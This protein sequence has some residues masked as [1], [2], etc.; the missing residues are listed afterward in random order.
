MSLTIGPPGDSDAAAPSD[1]SASVLDFRPPGLPPDVPIEAARHWRMLSRWMNLKNIA[2]DPETELPHDHSWIANRVK[3]DYEIDEQSRKEWKDKYRKWLE[4]ALQITQPKT[5]PWPDA[6]NVIYPLM[7]TAATQ[8]NARAYPA[9]IRDR[10]VV[11]GT[12]V[13]SDNGIPIPDPRTGGPLVNP[14]NGQPMWAVPPGA[15]QVRADLIGRHMSW[16]LLDEQEEWEP[17]TDRLLVVL[18]IVGCMF[19]KSYFGH[20]LRRNVS[21]TVDAIDLCVNYWAKSFETAPRKTQIIRKYPWEIQTA[22]RSG[23]FLSYDE[24]SLNL[25]YGRDVRT[26]EDHRPDDQQ[27]EDAPVTFLEQH[28]RMDLDDDGYQEPYVVT[29]ARDSVKLARIRPDFEMEGIRWAPDGRITNVEEVEYF[30]KYGFIPNP[31]STVYDLGFGHLLYPL[32]ESINTSLNMMF[33]AGHLQN[34][35]GGF[36]GSGLSIN[37]GAVRFALGEYKP[38]NTMGGSIRD[39]VFPLPFPGPSPVLMQLLTFL[40]E[41]A[42]RVAAVKDVMTGEMPPDNTSGLAL[43][44]TIEQGLNVFNAIYKRI[45]R[46]LGYEFRKLYRLNRIYLPE[47]G[48]FGRHGAWEEIRRADYEAGSGVE[49]VS[50]PKMVTDMQRLGRAQLLLNFKDDPGFD[51]AA[52]RKEILTAAMIPNPDRFLAQNPQPPAPILLKSR[53]LDIREK[54]EATDLALRAAHD[55][56]LMMREITQAEL[57]LA[58]ARKLDNDAGLSWAQHEL[59]RLKAQIDALGAITDAVSAQAAPAGGQPQPGNGAPAGP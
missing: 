13:G 51:G 20:T 41:A 58:Q 46:S 14:Q 29:I 53:E 16:Q 33:D 19:R 3:Q 52:I 59:D 44:A 39:N 12:V 43:L 23:E 18:P 30:T 10:N 21:E 31:E 42:E 36:V 35:G 38:V 54:R 24:D 25:G 15:K 55:R 8:F 57:N 17:Q 56:A 32:N 11:K 2:D 34:T 40:V 5:Y 26:T 22:V 4:F 45:Y 49:P 37:T 48:G 47:M 27:D 1:A 28:R 9:V 6:S 7:T 50:D